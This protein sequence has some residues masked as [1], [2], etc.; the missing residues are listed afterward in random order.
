MF[1]LPL[2]QSLS[3]SLS[4]YELKQRAI[5]GRSGA[6]IVCMKNFIVG[7]EVNLDL[8]ERISVTKVQ[9]THRL[10][11]YFLYI[12]SAGALVRVHPV[13]QFTLTRQRRPAKFQRHQRLTTPQALV[14]AEV[15]E[16]PG[17]AHLDADVSEESVAVEPAAPR[18]RYT[19]TRQLSPHMRRMKTGQRRLRQAR[20]GRQLRGWG[21]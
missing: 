8:P 1:T 21:P 16:A 18:P 10:P 11:L 3:V 14:L 17:A 9:T 5:G 7:D 6:C 19:R 2:F 13:F 4:V 15:E 20:L 12:F